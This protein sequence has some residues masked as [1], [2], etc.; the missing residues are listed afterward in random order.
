MAVLALQMKPVSPNGLKV[1]E[2]H[3][4]WRWDQTSQMLT[5]E[6]GAFF[7]E[8]SREYCV[9]KQAAQY[10]SVLYAINEGDTRVRH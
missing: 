4:V 6:T 2:M 10:M 8:K 1:Q 3:S 7:P 5:S 9:E